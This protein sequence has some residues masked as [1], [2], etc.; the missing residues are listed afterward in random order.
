MASGAV[1][2][3]TGRLHLIYWDAGYIKHAYYDHVGDWTEENVEAC[4]IY[5]EPAMALLK[6]GKILVTWTVD[7]TWH[8]KIL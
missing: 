3:K 8:K 7:R 6:D 1:D 2:P 5:C 4:P